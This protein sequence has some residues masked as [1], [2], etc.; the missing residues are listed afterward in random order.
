MA[1]S[2]AELATKIGRV[3]TAVDR[4]RKQTVLEMGLAAK[5][6]FLAGPPR[7]GLGRRS[8]LAG[9]KWGAG[10]NI[11]GTRNPTALVSYRGPVHWFQG[12]TRP[13]FI[14][15]K[16]FRGSRRSRGERA[17]GG[18][19]NRVSAAKV[20]RGANQAMRLPD[21]GIRRTVWH[22]GMRARPFFRG[23]KRQVEKKV[24]EVAAKRLNRNIRDAH[25]GR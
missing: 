3:A 11:K 1:R 24:P 7:V 25:W 2:A 9:A 8:R 13:H 16:G 10:F 17:A 4:G 18:L 23:V 21:G 5:D 12:G 22:P 20:G 19:G 14:T 15:P 6:E